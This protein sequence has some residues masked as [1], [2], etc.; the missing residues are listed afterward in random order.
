MFICKHFDIDS[1]KLIQ[2]VG[3]QTE[4]QKESLAKSRAASDNRFNSR[5]PRQPRWVQVR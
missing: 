1:I 5:A 4:A 3:G 2:V